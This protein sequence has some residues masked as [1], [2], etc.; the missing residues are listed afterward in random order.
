[1][2][3]SGP[4]DIA[5]DGLTA[6]HHAVKQG[7]FAGIGTPDDGDGG[8]VAH[9]KRHDTG[10]AVNTQVLFVMR[11]SDPDVPGSPPQG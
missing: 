7:G 1:M 11:Q 10:R 5:H 8:K 2:V 6:A 3:P 9:A 4:R